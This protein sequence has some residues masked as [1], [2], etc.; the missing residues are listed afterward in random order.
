MTAQ[1]TDATP[2]I[3]S[4]PL[5]PYYIAV[6]LALS[7]AKAPTVLLE[8]RFWA[9]E[10]D[11]YYATMRALPAWDA[12]TFVA[13]GNLQLLINLVVYV[14]T[15]VPILY[16]PAVTTYAAYLVELLVA[17]LIYR[18]VAACDINRLV[19]LLLLVAW[20]FLAPSYETWNS[21]T[22]IQWI[23]S[24]SLLFVLIMPGDAVGRNLGK[25]AVWAALC[26]LT[27]IASCALAPGFLARAYLDRSKAF[28]ILGAVLAVCALVQLA[29]ILLYGVGDRP[30]AFG[31]RTVMVP[32]LVQTVLTPLIGVE[33][34]ET[35]VGP[36]RQGVVPLA[37]LALVY[38]AAIPWMALAI[39]LAS[40]A[41]RV[42]LVAI[43]A[44]MWL[45]ASI[46]YTFG[47]LGSPLD[48]IS[49]LGG[50]RYYLLGA[51]CFCLLLAWGSTASAPLARYTATALLVLIAGVSV[52]QHLRS[53]WVSAFTQGP[54]WKAQIAQCVPQSPCVVAIWPQA[55]NR[56]IDLGTGIRP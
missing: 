35:F 23:C 51:M 28:A 43:V 21:I 19:G 5:L 16:A 41:A 34:V 45:L 6:F 14:S 8:P 54:S 37:A 44:A 47:A 29:I 53:A 18:F 46:F 2:G 20:L 32:M 27:G 7:V 39:G 36:V 33:R 4:I 3:T 38:L 10:G 48:L 22:N 30:L 9:E 31:P 55:Q 52:S 24:V 40:R 17:V 15:K 49:P 56:Q 12:L 26:G 11:V 50:A 42:E 13:K 1:R 25:W